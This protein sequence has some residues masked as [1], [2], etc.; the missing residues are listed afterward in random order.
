[1]VEETKAVRKAPACA[2]CKIQ[3]GDIDSWATLTD[4]QAGSVRIKLV[5]G[6]DDYC[7]VL[8]VLQYSNM[9]LKDVSCSSVCC[10]SACQ[11]VVFVR[12]C[13]FFFSCT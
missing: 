4:A 2:F 9:T 10:L 6:M 8:I 1:M 7:Y 13:V 11:L 3:D 5:D 12:D